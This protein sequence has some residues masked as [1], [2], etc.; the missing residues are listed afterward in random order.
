[1]LRVLYVDNGI[2]LS[3]GLNWELPESLQNQAGVEVDVVVPRV[4][5]IDE[6]EGRLAERLV[7]ISARVDGVDHAVRVYEGRRD[8]HVRA[9]YMDSEILREGLDLKDD[10]GITACAVYAHA[11]CQWLSKSPVAYDIVQVVGLQTAL[12]PTMMRCLY[13]DDSR[14]QSAR[15]VALVAGI[16]DKGTID[17]SWLG[18]LGLPREMGTSEG[19]EFYGKLSILNGVYLH[20]DVIAFPNDS[21][22]RRIEKNRGKDIGMEG[23]LFGRLDAVRTIRLGIAMKKTGPACDKAIAATYSAADMAGKNRCKSAFLKKYHLGKDRP[24]VAFVGRLDAESGIDL[25]ND[26]LDDLMDRQVALVIAGAGNDAYQAAVAGWCSE[27]KGSVAWIDHKPS[28]EEVCNILSAADVLLMPAKHECL[29]RLHLT[30]MQYGCVAVAR[31]TGAVAQD[32]HRVR[33]LEKI[34]DEDNG[35]TFLKYDSDEFYD[36]VMDA[37]DVYASPSWNDIRAHAMASCTCIC[38]TAED[39]VNIYNSLKG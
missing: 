26:I 32:I 6:G 22:R 3:G 16:E 1:M 19:M 7:S 20:A 9:F 39:C 21:V 10:R 34:T 38:K 13:A 28:R 12:V 18:R 36:A 17:M 29:C 37:L 14:V 27:F 5:N 11:V 25:V 24:L 33:N 4:S 15:S 23:A 2:C 30:A 31:N 35:F 8:S